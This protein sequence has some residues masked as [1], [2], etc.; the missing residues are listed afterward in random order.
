MCICMRQEDISRLLAPVSKRHSCCGG[1][2]GCTI[3]VA[4]LGQGV[5]FDD[6]CHAVDTAQRARY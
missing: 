6:V 4:G 2:R 1:V 3:V 5:D